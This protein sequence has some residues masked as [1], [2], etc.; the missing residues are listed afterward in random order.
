MSEADEEMARTPEE[1]RTRRPP[2]EEVT[3]TLSPD[4]ML[5]VEA[6]LTPGGDSLMLASSELKVELI[7]WPKRIRVRCWGND[8]KRLPDRFYEPV[9]AYGSHKLDCRCVHCESARSTGV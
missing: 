7:F 2:P 4:E 5:K 9:P 8:G 3:R 6:H 1:A